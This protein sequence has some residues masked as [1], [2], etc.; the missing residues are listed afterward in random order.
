MPPGERIRRSR[1]DTTAV[2][3]LRDDMSPSKERT[4]LPAGWHSARVSQI[5][6]LTPRRRL[7]LDAATTELRDSSVNQSS[8]R[9]VP[10]VSTYT[11]PPVV[12]A[13]SPAG[14]RGDAGRAHNQAE[15]SSTHP[16]SRCALRTRPGGAARL[17]QSDRYRGPS[18]RNNQ[19]RAMTW[20]QALQT[21]SQKL[22]EVRSAGRAGDSVFINGS[23]T[24][25][26]AFLDQ[27]LAASACR[28][29][30]L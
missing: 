13:L 4:E 5:P 30:E 9:T 15:A 23:E 1:R 29:L 10:G 20:D 11:Q 17:V 2:P 25:L 7:P 18:R 14:D 8:R 21:L 27:W 24:E 28:A 12:S 19:A 26:P 3:A 6:V 22:G 16:E